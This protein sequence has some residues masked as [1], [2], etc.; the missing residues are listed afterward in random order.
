MGQEKRG[1]AIFL[2]FGKES[3]KVFCFF[4]VDFNARNPAP[5][6]YFEEI[7]FLFL[8]SYDCMQAPEM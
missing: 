1:G 8:F 7:F 6:P 2:Q 4:S 3:G 5:I